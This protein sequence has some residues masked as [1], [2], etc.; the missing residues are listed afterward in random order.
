MSRSERVGSLQSR[1][2]S[3]VSLVALPSSPG[4]F[5]ASKNEWQTTEIERGGHDPGQPTVPAL[6]GQ[7]DLTRPNQA[8]KSSRKD[9][10]VWLVPG[11]FRD[12]DNV[13][14]P[15]IQ[16]QRK[17]LAQPQICQYLVLHAPPSSMT[18][19]SFAA[20]CFQAEHGTNQCTNLVFPATQ[21]AIPPS[22]LAWQLMSR[23]GL[24][25]RVAISID[26]LFCK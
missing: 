10:T 3:W 6:T 4:L 14:C 23:M 7:P 18:G 2:V 8:R 25:W 11:D 26:L 13:K 5:S 19:F 9:G 22:P 16:C 15:A 24:W 12:N 20:S 17:M 1:I 21:P